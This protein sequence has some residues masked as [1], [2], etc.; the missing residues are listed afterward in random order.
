MAAGE[1]GVLLM[2]KNNVDLL[3]PGEFNGKSNKLLGGMKARQYHREE[4]FEL[5]FK[6]RQK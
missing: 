3:I 2:V 6:I 1:S 5:I 4:G